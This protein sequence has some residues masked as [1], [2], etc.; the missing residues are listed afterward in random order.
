MGG[1]ALRA[2]H[3]CVNTLSQFDQC[4]PIQF[5]LRHEQRYCQTN[6]LRKSLFSGA[7]KLP[8]ILLIDGL[9][10]KIGYE[11]LDRECIEAIYA[12]IIRISQEHRNRLQI[13]MSDN[14]VPES[15]RAYV[16]AEFDD[17]RKL[18]LL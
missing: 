6:S 12:Y 1:E 3:K 17:D 14:T 15:V 5:L 2:S 10:G 16:F 13:I 8:N 9:S 7:L 11:G 18:I 4:W